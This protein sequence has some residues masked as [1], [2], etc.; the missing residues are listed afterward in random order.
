MAA[1]PSE[2]VVANATAVSATA[3]R[4][5]RRPGAWLLR[6][7]TLAAC[8][9]V[10]VYFSIAKPDT[11]PT[12]SNLAGLLTLA[13]PLML[14]AVVLTVPLRVGD[15]DLSIGYQTQFYSAFAVVMVAKAG[16]S[17][18]AAVGLTLLAAVVIGTVLGLLVAYTG[19]SAFVVTLAAGT[20]LLGLEIQVSGNEQISRGIPLEFTDMATAHLAAVPVPIVVEVIAI[21]LLWLVQDRTVW[22]RQVAAV[23][24]SYEAAKLSGIRVELVRAAAFSLV[25]CGCAL[26]GLLLAAQAQSYYPNAAIGLLLPAYAACFL[27][28]TILR[29]GS[30]HVVGTAVGVLFLAALQNG[31]VQ[32][33]YSPA[34]A[35]IIQGL[36]LALAVLA[37][38]LGRRMAR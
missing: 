9:L 13:A 8:V 18:V 19:V 36:V 29:P 14:M 32:L 1:P 25:G 7:G 16:L 12:W 24:A 17:S 2:P 27:G 11:Y 10:L 22:G 38:Q 21:A 3:P 31:I 35:N 34:V 20:I 4:A 5:R 26:A 15:F 37:S 30:F 33:N 28:S 6:Y 23:G